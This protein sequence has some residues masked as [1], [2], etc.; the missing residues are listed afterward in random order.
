[1]HT[2][3]LCTLSQCMGGY[4]SCMIWGTCIIVR[5][6]FIQTCSLVGTLSENLRCSEAWSSCSGSH[7]LLSLFNKTNTKQDE[8]EASESE[9]WRNERRKG[10]TWTCR[11]CRRGQSDSSYRWGCAVW[12][13]EAS[14]CCSERGQEVRPCSPQTTFWPD[15]QFCWVLP[16]KQR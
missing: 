2:I 7:L 9:K 8:S 12:P 13:C 10:F 6:G 15:P 11:C 14:D 16:T 3:C 1:M 5:L 4:E